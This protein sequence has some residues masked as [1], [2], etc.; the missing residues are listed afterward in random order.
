MDR[1]R[2]TSLCFVI[3]LAVAPLPAH[4]QGT[5]SSFAARLAALEAAVAALQAGLATEA[6]TRA[7]ADATLQSNINA[8]VAASAAGDTALQG[9]I[10]AEATARAAGDSTLQGQIDKL[11]GNIV[12]A[13][14]VGTYAV[15]FVSTA[16]DGPPNQ[17]IS[18]VVKGTATLAAD[19]TGSASLTA[20]GISWT[21]GTPAQ[22]WA[23]EEGGEV[24][25]FDF[26]WSYSGG[27]FSS[28]SSH[29]FGDFSL[30][31]AAGGQVMVTA[32]GGAPGNNQ[33]L[34]VWTRK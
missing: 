26:T 22:N 23:R 2:L 12:P 6:G 4:A 25:E 19:N 11:N 30:S 13:D 14:L 33:F 15:H 8:A 20:A 29:E 17:I 1:I 28:A 32:E 9:N 10:N 34:G 5:T 16:M 24:I 31:V 27:T 7:A 21:E 18:Y 3:G